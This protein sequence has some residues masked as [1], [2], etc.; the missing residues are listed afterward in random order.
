MT[1][2]AASL[3]FNIMPKLPST[4]GELFYFFM[5]MATVLSLSIVNFNIISLRATMLLGGWTDWALEVLLHSTP[6][7]GHDSKG[8]PSLRLPLY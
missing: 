8:L 6:N 1:F 3:V 2:I 7:S 5:L 4:S